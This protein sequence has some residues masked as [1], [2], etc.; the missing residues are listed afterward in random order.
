[1][2]MPLVVVE[3]EE[4]VVLHLQLQFQPRHLAL[5]V[6]HPVRVTHLRLVYH[7]LVDTRP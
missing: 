5:H 2:E 3:E 7:P 1:M 4:V 6:R